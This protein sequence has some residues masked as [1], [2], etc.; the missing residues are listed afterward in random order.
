M[1][2]SE[3]DENL[4]WDTSLIYKE[5]DEYYKEIEEIKKLADDLTKYKGKITENTDNLLNF[6]KD[7]EKLMRKFSKAAVYGH[8]KSDEDTSDSTYQQMNQTSTIAGAEVSEKLSFI[9]PEILSADYEDIK[10]KC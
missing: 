3:I 6:L 9:T 5:D 1:K 4:K 8:L 2:R 7:Y 10:K